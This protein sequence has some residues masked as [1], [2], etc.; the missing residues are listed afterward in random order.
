MNELVGFRRVVVCV[1]Q[2]KERNRAK[3]SALLILFFELAE[4]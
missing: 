2:K 4:T 3:F 1:K